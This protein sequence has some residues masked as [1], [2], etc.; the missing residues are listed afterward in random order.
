MLCLCRLICCDIKDI[1]KEIHKTS[2]KKKKLKKDFKYIDFLYHWLFK[3]ITENNQNVKTV[4]ISLNSVFCVYCFYFIFCSV[5]FYSLVGFWRS[6]FWPMHGSKLG[7]IELCQGIAGE[8]VSQIP[9][10]AFGRA[11][12]SIVFTTAMKQNKPI[13]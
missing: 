12:K 2:C 1:L 6:V 10:R 7:L 3:C 4:R 11:G 8:M 13:C 5:M 9:T